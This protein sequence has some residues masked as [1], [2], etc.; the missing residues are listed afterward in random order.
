MRNIT[1]EAVTS[2]IC[3]HQ[4]FK[5]NTQVVREGDKVYMY[6]HGNCIAKKYNGEV[7]LSTA[8]WESNTTKERLNGLLD[9]MG[10]NIRIMQKDYVW[11]YCNRDVKTSVECGWESLAS[12][13]SRLQS[14]YEEA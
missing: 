10:V 4:Y 8:G 9:Y 3:G 13:K 2:F 1:K 14:A 5:S 7:Y 11:Y 6:L 12:I